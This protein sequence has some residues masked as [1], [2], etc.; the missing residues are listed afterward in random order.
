MFERFTDTA[1]KTMTF[2]KEQ[3]VRFRNDHIA[4]EHILLGLLQAG[5]V[6][7]EVLRDCGLECHVFRQE[8]EKAI[9]EGTAAPKGQ[10][11]FAPGAKKVLELALEESKRLGHK[12]IGTEHI[13]LG[14]V[15]EKEGIAARAL[16]KAGVK[17]E[18]VRAKAAEIGAESGSSAPAEP[19]RLKLKEQRPDYVDRILAELEEIRADLD[20]VKKMLR[21]GRKAD[22]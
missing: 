6:V 7:G 14:L 12:Y 1:R 18:A 19:S 20:D 10:I 17:L 21:E 11:P 5:G 16:A 2:A 15:R 9:P 8:V 4:T 3:A 13:L 22:G